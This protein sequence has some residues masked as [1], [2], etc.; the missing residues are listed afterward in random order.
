MMR[1]SGGG[2]IV[3]CPM[4]ERRI[5]EPKLVLLA[6]GAV[7]VMLLCIVAIADSD[8]VWLVLLTVLAVG[9]IGGVIV[10]DLRRVITATG[11]SAAEVEAPPG[12][13]IV[14]STMPMTAEE[15]L[16]VVGASDGEQRSIMVVCPAGLTGGGLMAH[17]HDYDR[18]RRSEATTVAA[19]R[20]AGI[21]AA[22]QVGDRNPTHAV[23]DALA[24]F[25]AG[26][27]VIVAQ[28]PE[29]AVYREHLDMGE[30]QSR[31]RVEVH[32]RHSAPH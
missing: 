9:L 27:V 32:V 17:E 8:A 25:P 28:G 1:R 5:A 11:D 4:S 18:A 10:L 31:T 3:P 16:E 13:A 7:I 24:L 23:E 2:A 14:V 6:S 20:R 12:R 21:N 29:A 30:L 26:K 19:L 22:G 15:V